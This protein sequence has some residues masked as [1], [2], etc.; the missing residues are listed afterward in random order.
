MS[1]T[2]VIIED[3]EHNLYLLS[4]LLRANGVR[5]VEAR[6][7]IEGITRVRETRPDL[8]LL[9]IQIPGMDGLEVARLLRADGATASIPIVAVTSHAM[10]GDRERI[11]AAGCVES[12]EKPIDPATFVGEVLRFTP[13]SPAGEEG[14]TT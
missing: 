8:V 5:V 9:D 12:I 4:Y 3:N 10:V 11:L 7:G 6:D 2:V 14:E 1:A 13:A